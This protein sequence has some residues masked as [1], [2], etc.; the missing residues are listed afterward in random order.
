MGSDPSAVLGGGIVVRA[1]SAEIVG[2]VLL[3]AARRA[4]AAALA[5][6]AG[7][8][9]AAG[10]EQRCH[11]A[12]I[13]RQRRS[14]ESGGD[15]PAATRIVSTTRWYLGELSAVVDKLVL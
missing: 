4:A 2:S 7:K 11:D 10:A 5:G 12:E 3:G 6:R 14:V 8:T 15:A 13:A 9:T 1:A